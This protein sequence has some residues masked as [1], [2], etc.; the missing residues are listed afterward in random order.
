MLGKAVAQRGSGARQRGQPRRCE[1]RGPGQRERPRAGSLQPPRQVAGSKGQ[2]ERP[3]SLP[4]SW[5]CPSRACSSDTRCSARC[6]GSCQEQGKEA[7]GVRASPLDPTAVAVVAAVADREA[8]LFSACSACC[9]HVLVAEGS[10]VTRP[11]ASEP[12]CPSSTRP[13]CSAQADGL[14]PPPPRCTSPAARGSLGL[15][16]RAPPHPCRPSR[17]HLPRDHVKR[18]QHGL[19][20]R[21]SEPSGCC[22]TSS[23]RRARDVGPE[24]QGWLAGGWERHWCPGARMSRVSPHCSGGGHSPQEPRSVLRGALGPCPP[25]PVGCK[26]GGEGMV[27]DWQPWLPVQVVNA[28]A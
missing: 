13:A 7:S 3:S 21:T 6:P 1:E 11:T 26:G 10:A 5:F 14:Q 9:W 16:P 15:G 28:G 4:R 24:L 17:G 12:A 22:P 27:P 25:S 8:W 2:A 18:W 19:Q 20:R 23:L